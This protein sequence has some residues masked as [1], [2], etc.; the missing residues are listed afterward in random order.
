MDPVLENVF[1]ELL[2]DLPTDADVPVV[3]SV[4]ERTWLWSDLH[5]SDP[6]VVLGSGRP[7]GSVEEMNRHLLRNWRRRVG[8]GDTVICLGDVAH[9][10]AWRDNC[11]VLDLAECPG[12]RLLVLGN[13]DIDP[14]NQARPGEVHRTAVTLAAPGEPPLLLTHV[15]LLQVPHGCVNVHGHVHQKESPTKNRHINV[16]VEQLDYRPVKAERIRRLARRLLEGRTVPGRGTRMR[17]NLMEA[18]VP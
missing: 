6:S 14:V 5:L 18:T 11:L 10:E 16:S 9:P 3:A 4:P 1:V 13:H 2:V 15:P 8:A 7:F 12:D 17:L